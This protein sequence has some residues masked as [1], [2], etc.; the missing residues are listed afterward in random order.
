MIILLDIDGVML[1]EPFEEMKILPDAFKEFTQTSVASLNRLLG[2]TQAEIVL[3]TNHRISFSNDEWIAIFRARNIHIDSISKVND[4]DSIYKMMDRGTE[5][6]EWVDSV[7]FDTN[8]VI[9]DDD[10]AINTL[11]THIKNRWV[12]TDPTIGLNDVA[13]NKALNIL[14][15]NTY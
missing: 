13:T 14:L 6:K 7:G 10:Y 1:P 9:I 12:M 5:I 2:D 8:Y 15:S 4:L 11:P 3:T